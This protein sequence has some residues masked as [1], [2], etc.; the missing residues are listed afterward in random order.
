MNADRTRRAWPL[1][2]ALFCLVV[3]LLVLVWLR[4]AGLSWGL[5]NAQHFFSYHPDEALLLVP[6]LGFAQGDWNPHYFR[7]GTLYIYLV[8]IPAVLL[9]LGSDLSQFPAGLAR[10]YLLGRIVTALL[11]AATVLVL[12]LALRRESRH[13]AWISA[14]LLAVCPL[15]VVHSY[16]ATVDVPA[17]FF[18][19]LAFLLALR[20]SEDGRAW[21]AVLTG[22]AVGCAA[23]TKYNM[24]LY[25]FPALVAPLLARPR[26]WRWIWPL[27]LVAGA[28]VGFM[29]GCPYFWTTE[30]RDG[31]LS[32]IR[33]ARVGGT[34]AFVETGSGWLYHLLGG[35]PVGLGFP[36]LAAA[37]VGVLAAIR[38]PSRAARLSLVWLGLYLLVIGFGRERFIRYLVPLTP[39]L[40]VLA[41]TGLQWL[42]TLGRRPFPRLAAHGLAGAVPALT[43]LYA[44]GQALLF[45]GPDPRDT[46]W[47]RVQPAVTSPNLRLRVGLTQE[48]WFFHPPV[49][50][51]NAGPLSRSA[52]EDWNEKAGG[53]VVV[54]GWQAGALAEPAPDVFFLSDLESRDRLRL[55][56][57]D[58]VSFVAALNSTYTVRHEFATAAPAWSTWPAP[59]RRHAPPDWLY[60]DPHITMYHNPRPKEP[61]AGSG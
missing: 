49:S 14:V 45:V 42:V 46:A 39:F 53:R 37:V 34:F 47:E 28:A 24:A 16:Y 56:D 12:Y 50:P 33:Y 7:Y 5:P 51:F 54:T 25:I 9:H 19:T 30:F 6:S 32:T 40:C 36:L 48:P 2:A 21:T 59:G 15:H 27:A 29:L 31:L 52:F 26:A 23:A 17:T 1:P 10:L 41:A 3:N 44:I 18:V 4:T 58:A 8:G 11:G 43:L 38:L 61:R 20:Y 13:L 35:L 57:P 60:P 22:L 55:G